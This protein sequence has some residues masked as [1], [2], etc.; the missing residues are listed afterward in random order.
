MIKDLIKR[1]RS[2]RRFKKG[3]KII[4]SPRILPTF[5]KIL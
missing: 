3:F 5:E 2:I 4:V 1:N